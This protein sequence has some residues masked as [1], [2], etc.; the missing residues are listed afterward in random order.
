MP[1]DT[2]IPLAGIGRRSS[3]LDDFG[4]AA[5]AAE[6]LQQRD[7]R[8][9]QAQQAQVAGARRQQAESVL[10]K[11]TTPDGGIDWK[12]AR[13]E[14]MR[15]EPKLAMEYDKYFGEA[16]KEKLQTEKLLSENKALVDKAQRSKLL[17]VDTYIGDLDIT[18]PD[19]Q[20][21]YASRRAIAKMYG[22]PDEYLPE[23]AT[24]E[25]LSTLQQTAKRARQQQQDDLLNSL[26]SQYL[27]QQIA[28]AGLENVLKERELA[29]KTLE[30]QQKEKEALEAKASAAQ[31]VTGNL[32]LVDQTLSHPGFVS[33]LSLRRL[34][35]SI[36]GTPERDFSALLDRV[37]STLTIENRQKLK[38]Q[39]QI[40]DREQQMLAESA[41]T[42]DKDLSPDALK[43]ELMR[44]K[45]IFEAA[46][47]RN[48]AQGTPQ[49]APAAPAQG[50]KKRPLSEILK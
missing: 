25:Y 32:S 36:P 10:G 43:Q 39:G 40:S 33:G 30:G 19:Y 15:I 13:P 37:R 1:L 20:A 45:G 11:Y 14:M 5:Q 16:D 50:G 2:S 48:A 38:G 8:R 34:K 35:E 47:Q 22:M 26:K 44:I 9:E 49:G 21:Q 28:G 12:Q 31:A 18:K 27:G 17:D 24:P 23:N 3:F 4:Q 6:Y 46:A 41:T 7:V 42:L 29:A